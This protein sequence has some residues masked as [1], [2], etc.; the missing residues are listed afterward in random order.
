M[1]TFA[2]VR[3]AFNPTVP[4]NFTELG[5]PESLV[6]DL[7]LRRM[8][9]EGYCSL[10]GLGRS[11]RLAV[12]VIDIVFKHMRSQQLVEVKGM[13]G[14]DYNFTLSAAGKQLAGERF[15]ISQYAGACP[16]SL[17]D[18]HAATKVQAA[19]V[20]VDR[21]ALRQAF[22]DLVVSD[23][24]LDQLGPAII[25]QSSIFVYGPTGNGKTSLAERMLRVYH[26]A[27]LIPYAVEVDNQVISLYDP[28]VHT[29]LEHDE[30]DLDQRWILCKRPC[31]VVGG[32]LIPSMLEL[33]LDEASG[34]YAAP[35]QMKANNGILI[36]DDFGRQLM[37]PRDLL[38][39]WIVPLDRRVD[40]LT[41]RYG[42]KFQI[43]FE[44]MVVFS[45]NLEPSDL[46]DE[47]FLRRIH[48]KIY[49]EAVDPSSFDQIFSRVVQSRNIQAEPDSAEY[50]RR[51]CLREGRTELRACYPADICNI[52][53]SI[54][55]YEGRGPIM[56]K[57]E[58]ERAAA[59][60]FA[61]G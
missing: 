41:L 6:L 47:A 1:A 59:L 11:L 37:S 61:K 54:G 35:L 4:Q 8:L 40:Y 17:K 55:R 24:M 22:V 33:R 13:T 51:L 32:E 34:I 49:V 19:K 56:T 50:L 5:V 26:D 45:T 21:S 44:T 25:S 12:P 7:V 15:Q 36:I 23:R 48:N 18:Y 3:S 60:Y 43:P 46:A 38:N 52:L 30:T 39:R 29:P 58:M 57:P 53:S 16:V 31:I 27:V 10:Q 28:V 9:I 14:N 20:H 42:V 2:P